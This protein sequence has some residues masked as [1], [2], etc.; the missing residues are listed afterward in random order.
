MVDF[1]QNMQWAMVI[2]TAISLSHS[3]SCSG[4]LLLPFSIILWPR[5]QCKT[6]TRSRHSCRALK[7]HDIAI[8]FFFFRLFCQQ[9]HKTNTN[10]NIKWS[11]TDIW[12]NSYISCCVL[13]ILLKDVLNDDNRKCA[14]VL[15]VVSNRGSHIHKNTN[16]AT[17]CFLAVSVVP[18]VRCLSLSCAIARAEQNMELR[19]RVCVALRSG[20]KK[21][22]TDLHTQCVCVSLVSCKCTSCSTINWPMS[23]ATHFA[24]HTHIQYTCILLRLYYT[25]VHKQRGIR[26]LGIRLA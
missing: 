21:E 23:M 1:E 6:R 9:Q 3:H 22:S 8:G 14:H 11:H 15:T 16:R 20:K 4:V 7:I 19:W 25:R 13:L 17:Q 24:R 12:H 2:Q 18:T 10:A 5:C 26:S